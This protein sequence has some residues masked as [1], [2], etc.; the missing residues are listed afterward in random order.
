MG[1]GSAERRAGKN[2]WL[3]EAMEM[4]L[5]CLDQRFLDAV[6]VELMRP[7]IISGRPLSQAG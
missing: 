2:R 3:L 1:T 4:R 7:L 6:L 5:P